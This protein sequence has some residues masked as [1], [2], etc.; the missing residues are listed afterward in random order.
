VGPGTGAGSGTAA[1]PKKNIEG[2][3]TVPGSTEPRAFM[4][5]VEGGFSRWVQAGLR[6]MWVKDEQA[7]EGSGA[8]RKARQAGAKRLSSGYGRD[9]SRS[10]FGTRRE[11]EAPGVREEGTT[12]AFEDAQVRSSD[13]F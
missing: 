6:H 1:G 12:S 8:T 9:A 11:G 2:R 13:G 5:R 4:G 3:F 10:G 7:R